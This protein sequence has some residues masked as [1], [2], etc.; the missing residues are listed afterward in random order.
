MTAELREALEFGLYV[1]VALAFATSP[2][3]LRRW[4][5][6]ERRLPP[7]L[8]PAWMV[9]HPVWPGIALSMLFLTLVSM[10]LV[11]KRGIVVLLSWTLL[12]AAMYRL[13]LQH[14]IVNKS[15]MILLVML[16]AF[17]V[18]GII[19]NFT[20]A[21]FVDLLTVEGLFADRWHH[22]GAYL[23]SARS[24]SSGLVIH[25]DF[26]SQYGLGPSA[27]ISL[28]AWNGGW[29]RGLFLSAGLAQLFA[30]MALA[31]MAVLVVNR[32]A[33]ANPVLWA[34]ALLIVL[35]NSAFWA[36]GPGYSNFIPSLG[37]MRYLPAVLI[38]ACAIACVEDDGRFPAAC[39]VA[40]HGL[41]LFGAVWSIESLVMVC[42]IWWPLYVQHRLAGSVS[43]T[44]LLRV[45][46]LASIQIVATSA[47]LGL[48]AILIFRVSYGVWPDPVMFTAFARNV[49]GSLPIDVFGPFLL[50]AF[51]AIAGLV[52]LVQIARD[53]GFGRDFTTLLSLLLLSHAA[54]LYYVGR[55]HDANIP[56]IFPYMGLVLLFLA[57]DR[58][59]SVLRHASA[60]LLALMVSFL[61]TYEFARVGGPTPAMLRFEW[62]RIDPWVV[63]Q[64]EDPA[65]SDRGIAIRTITAEFG[66]G[67]TAFDNAAS[68]VATQ[69]QVEW[70]AYNNT[71]GYYGLP[72]ELQ[73]LAIRRAK[74]R[75]MRPGWV[76]L[77]AKD[78]PHGRAYVLD[79]F[80][81][82]YTIAE[83]RLFGSVEA[84]RFMPINTVS[85]ARPSG[86]PT[87]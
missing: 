53:E 65:K 21:P 22:W 80:S 79:L 41:W 72:Y 50:I 63:E 84:I 25:H 8:G 40:L 3:W 45:S 20:T 23:M 48:L 69:P 9:R 1:L 2:L 32:R 85:D 57:V 62:D 35:V 71:T 5:S 76:I 73:L 14:A 17:F 54:T 74:E 75:L 10:E 82:D 56:S 30:I 42:L 7:G 4:T 46:T 33:G 15:R 24:F 67:I 27:L 12:A 31:A 34:M 44:G 58:R 81:R 11:A 78:P 52:R 68:V 49:P 87:P 70:T 13:L 77:P 66:E 26:P 19:L 43:D 36:G 6:G 38:A 29:S 51:V 18:V 64:F 60:S 39:V 55:S 59:P 28:L 83:T 37:A 86:V 47:T 61:V 16:G